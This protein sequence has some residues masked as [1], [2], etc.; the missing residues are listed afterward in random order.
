MVFVLP[1]LIE[2]DLARLR[3]SAAMAAPATSATR[4]SVEAGAGSVSERR[5][6]VAARLSTSKEKVPEP[7]AAS[8]TA[9]TIGVQPLQPDVS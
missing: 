8:E 7:S 5:S 6:R 2:S 9:E 4:M 3:V 1:P